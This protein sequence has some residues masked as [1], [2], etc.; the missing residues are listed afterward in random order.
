MSLPSRSADSTNV[1]GYLTAF[2][3][4]PENGGTI[5]PLNDGTLLHTCTI[6]T[7]HNLDLTKQIFVGHINMKLSSEFKFV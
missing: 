5:F 7:S 4:H 2:A 6:F 3:L 1:A